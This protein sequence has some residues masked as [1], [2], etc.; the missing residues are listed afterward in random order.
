MTQHR[1]KQAR[2]VG[3]CT[4]NE[5]AVQEVPVY[6]QVCSAS[7]WCS[8]STG[9]EGTRIYKAG[10][11]PGRA[12][13]YTLSY[14]LYP[15]CSLVCLPAC[16]PVSLSVSLSPSVPPSLTPTHFVHAE[17]VVAP[18]LHV[19]VELLPLVGDGVPDD[20]TP[21]KKNT[22]QNKTKQNKTRNKTRNKRRTEDVEDVGTSAIRQ[23]PVYCTTEVCAERGRYVL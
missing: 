10:R 4:Q 2:Q 15:G 16:L 22:K 6:F 13:L 23:F 3:A 8:S 9:T 21:E 14:C 17:H 18:D 5:T 12:S 20:L 11:R 1:S 7:V 19:F